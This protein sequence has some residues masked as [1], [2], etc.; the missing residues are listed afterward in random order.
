M[1][2]EKYYYKPLTAVS[3]PTLT[4]PMTYRFVPASSTYFSFNHFR[5][6]ADDHSNSLYKYDPISYYHNLGHKFLNNFGDGQFEI[7]DLIE[8][9]EFFDIEVNKIG[10][11]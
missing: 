9:Q 6:F 5:Y 2:N 4:N 11:N 7:E 10:M 1:F 3:L 8:N